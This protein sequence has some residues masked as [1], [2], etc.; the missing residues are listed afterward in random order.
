MP[1]K[2]DSDGGLLVGGLYDHLVE[3]GEL[4]H[5]SWQWGDVA[6]GD[7][8]YL[9]IRCGDAACHISMD[10]GLDGDWSVGLHEA[11]TITTWGVELS[12]HPMNRTIL[13]QA[14]TRFY[15]TT[16]QPAGGTR[17]IL[18]R[19]GTTVVDVGQAFRGHWALAPNTNYVVTMTN[20]S[21]SAASASVLATFYEE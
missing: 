12:A 9:L 15:H 3:L 8:Q 14:R 7:S 2:V 17:L 10:F 5:V 11:P 18:L 19:A 21:G 6:D 1:S 13:T 20:N 4:F 16:T